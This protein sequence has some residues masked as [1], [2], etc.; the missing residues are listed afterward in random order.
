MVYKPEHAPGDLAPVAGTYELLNI[1]G[2]PTG[3]RISVGRSHP[4]P[5]APSGHN[6][7]LAEDP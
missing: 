4:F 7:V 6:W 5:A 3:I 2:S 1:F